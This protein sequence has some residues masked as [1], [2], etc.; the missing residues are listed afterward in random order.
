[1]SRN[2]PL[3]YVDHIREGLTELASED[4]QYA[5][6]VDPDDARVGSFVEAICQV[7]DDSGLSRALEKEP[8]AVQ[9]MLGSDAVQRLE[10]LDRACLAI[11]Q[12]LDDAVL[13]PSPAMDKVQ[14]LAAAALD[15]IDPNS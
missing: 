10:E 1:M 2:P 15:A 8:E 14:R 7:W 13:I 3:I 9:E 5:V 6:W 11:D 4:L 12:R